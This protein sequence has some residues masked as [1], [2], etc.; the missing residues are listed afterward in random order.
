MDQRH[1][2]LSV[3]QKERIDIL[4][5]NYRKRTF[6]A[7][8]DNGL[9]PKGLLNE[10]ISALDNSSIMNKA[11]TM[12]ISETS[13]ASASGSSAKDEGFDDSIKDNLEKE[14]NDLPRLIDYMDDPMKVG[15]TDYHK[16][17]DVSTMDQQ[18]AFEKWLNDHWLSG[19][20]R[21]IFQQVVKLVL[22]FG[23]AFS[24]KS[25]DQNKEARGFVASCARVLTL[26]GDCS[27]SRAFI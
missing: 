8:A 5:K 19:R 22:L 14:D 12:D 26:S 24:S 3:S 20:S 15:S 2:Y 4:F 10:S 1:P 13:R 9:M 25:A 17:L 27:V 7:M 23:P 18:D 21:H 16:I 6:W 11:I